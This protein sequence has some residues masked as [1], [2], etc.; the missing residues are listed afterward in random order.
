MNTP[1]TDEQRRGFANLVKEAQKEYEQSFEKLLLSIKNEMSPRLESRSRVAQLMDDIRNF[2]AKLTDAADNLRRFG[3][4]VID[5]GIISV[6]YDIER[7]GRRLYEDKVKQA[8]EDHER[9][10][11]GFR[12]ATFDVYAAE[13]LEDAR[14]IVRGLVE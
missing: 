5:D 8:R 3:F 13:S 10:T 4:R 14:D 9:A 1:L 7:D 2:R 11:A 6:D 12:K